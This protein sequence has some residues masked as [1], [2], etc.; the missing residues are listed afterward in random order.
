[1]GWVAELLLYNDGAE[2]YA[3]RGGLLR[4]SFP[5]SLPSGGHTDLRGGAGRRRPLSAG[6]AGGTAFLTSADA[7]RSSM[8]RRG[9]PLAGAELLAMKTSKWAACWVAAAAEGPTR[10][11]T[12]LRRAVARLPAT[13]SSSSG[14]P[15]PFLAPAS[16]ASMAS[17]ASISR[18]AV[19]GTAARR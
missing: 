6:S 10:G 5:R 16:Y 19:V 18:R 3:C 11:R 13:A 4:L 8:G 15:S 7:R 2:G 1:M 12:P 17:P 9:A 14:P